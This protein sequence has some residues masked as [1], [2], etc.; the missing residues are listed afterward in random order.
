MKA[1]EAVDD[2]DLAELK[3]KLQT[4]QAMPAVMTEY[5]IMGMFLYWAKL[6]GAYWL[7]DFKRNPEQQQQFLQTF[8]QTSMAQ[9]AT[10]PE[11][12]VPAV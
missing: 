4:A 5:D 10:P 11:Q 7:K 3:M 8:Q 6:K 2:E 12:Q 9:N 1:Q